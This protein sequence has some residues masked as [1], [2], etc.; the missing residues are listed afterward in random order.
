VPDSADDLDRRVRQRRAVAKATRSGR[1]D[2]PKP[3]RSGAMTRPSSPGPVQERGS[4]PPGCPV[5]VHEQ[6]RPNPGG[7]TPG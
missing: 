7:G 5:A 6:H 3:G 1:A 4:I 2:R